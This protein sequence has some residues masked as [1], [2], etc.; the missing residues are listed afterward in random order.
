MRA[1]SRVL[2]VEDHPI[3]RQGLISALERGLPGTRCMAVGS[4]D[5]ALAALAADPCFDV[6][7]IDIALDDRDGLSLAA[8]LRARWP[9][10]VCAVVS[11]YDDAPLVARARA[12]GCMGFL[13]KTLPP[14]A[15]VERFGRMLAGEPCFTS[16]RQDD[17]APVAFTERQAAVLERVARGLSSRTIAVELG[18]AERTVK[19]HLAVIFAR[20]EA[21]TRAE[22]VARAAALGLLPVMPSLPSGRGALAARR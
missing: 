19:D 14:E 22:A 7:L 15:L 10:L 2:V 12:L 17:A 21:S 5:E 8:Q 20:L 6:A 1:A 18:I 11:A 3:Y 4:A 9:T 16:R 13:S